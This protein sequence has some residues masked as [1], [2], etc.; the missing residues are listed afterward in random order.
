MDTCSKPE[1]IRR[2]DDPKPLFPGEHWAVLAVGL[3][4]WLVTRRNPSLS[5]RRSERA[6]A[7]PAGAC[8][9]SR[10]SAASIERAAP[11]PA[12]CRAPAGSIATKRKSPSPV[13]N[14]ASGKRST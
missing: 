4:A 14:A 13:M 7:Q 10:T 11:K 6:G 3:A 12:T 2:Y 5:V 8:K 9:A 1:A